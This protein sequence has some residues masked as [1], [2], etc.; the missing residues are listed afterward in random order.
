MDQQEIERE[1]LAPGRSVP[2]DVYELERTKGGKHANIMKYN[3]N[4]FGG[5]EH[6]E[7]IVERFLDGIFRFFPQEATKAGV[8]K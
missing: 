5:P 3:L 7:E 1:A 4:Q 2:G 8:H 6:L